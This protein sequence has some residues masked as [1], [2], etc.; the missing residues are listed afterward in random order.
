LSYA[1]R[2]KFFTEAVQLFAGEVVAI[3]INTVPAVDLQVK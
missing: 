1:A 2:R 3:E